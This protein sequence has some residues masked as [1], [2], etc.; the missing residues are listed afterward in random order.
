[1]KKEKKPMLNL[2]IARIK[3]GIGQTELSRKLGMYDEAISAYERGTRVPSIDT[4]KK[5]ADVLGCD[6]KEIL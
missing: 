6:V 5:I 4:C 2:K 1:M 3:A